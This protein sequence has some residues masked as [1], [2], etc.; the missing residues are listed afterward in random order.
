M[1]TSMEV[2]GSVDGDAFFVFLEDCAGPVPA[3]AVTWC[4]WTT[5]PPTRA[6]AC[7]RPAQARGAEVV[8]LPRYSPDF[9]P[10]EGAWSKLKAYL[11]QCGGPH[12]R[13]R[14]SARW[15]VGLARISARNARGW[16]KHAGYKTE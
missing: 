2:E 3:S 13:R 11:R 7:A 15:P 8:F 5:C 4:S 6:R 10:I 1:L 9:N 12:A 16:F 14:W